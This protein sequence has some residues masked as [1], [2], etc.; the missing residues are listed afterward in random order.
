M[1]KPDPDKPR[2]DLPPDAVR[3]DIAASLLGLTGERIRQLARAG[4]AELPARGF[5]AL[6]SLLS[7]Y[8]RYLRTEAGRPASEAMS[9]AHDAK[10]GLLT[11]ATDRRRAELVKREDAEAALAVI[12][13][14][15][16]RHLRGL[17]TA[18]A[19]RGLPPEVAGAV[20]REVLAAVER[21]EAREAEARRALLSG[22]FDGLTEG[23]AR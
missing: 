3:I 16:A 18:R 6:T 5:V 2:P 13:T 11:A 1:G 22:D 14:T 17:T 7:G 12:R 23:A 4:F 10:A 15:A 21:I 19:L 9:R 20:R 8:A